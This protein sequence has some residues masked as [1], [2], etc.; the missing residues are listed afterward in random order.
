LILLVFALPGCVNTVSFCERLLI[1]GSDDRKIKLWDWQLGKKVLTFDSGH[2]DNVFQAR[3]IPASSFTIASSSA[4]GQIRASVLSNDGISSS[5]RLWQHDGR[6]HKIALSIYPS[7]FLSCGEDGSIVCHDVRQKHAAANVCVFNSTRR[8]ELYSIHTNPN[9]RSEFCVG[10]QQKDISIFDLRKYGDSERAI[11]LCSFRPSC[12]KSDDVSCTAA[13]YNRKGEILAS[14]N[15][16][17][18]YLFNRSIHGNTTLQDFRCQ[19]EYSGGT[20]QSPA[21][22]HQ[23]FSSSASIMQSNVGDIQAYKVSSMLNAEVFRMQN[24]EE[25]NA[26][27]LTT[28]EEILRKVSN[29]VSNEEDSSD[30][31]ESSLTD[32]DEEE[33]TSNEETDNSVEMESEGETD[34]DGDPS[35]QLDGGGFHFSV[36]NGISNVFLGTFFLQTNRNLFL[37]R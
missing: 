27:Y 11:H 32:T 17:F 22:I 28:Y 30:D 21:E 23:F 33:I 9:N 15:D 37:L 7:T 35:D 34:C 2:I 3:C 16:D 14:Y 18:I 29:S 26:N 6:A 10:G 20:F 5:R 25:D 13:I 24:A 36:E 1:S 19:D 4:D 31:D 8:L 12:L